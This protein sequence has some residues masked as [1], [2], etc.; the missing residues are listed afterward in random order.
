VCKER[1]LADRAEELGHFSHSIEQ[2]VHCSDRYFYL[3]AINIYKQLGL[4]SNWHA[5]RP[6]MS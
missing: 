1:E 3:P 5:F 6:L 4:E 2:N